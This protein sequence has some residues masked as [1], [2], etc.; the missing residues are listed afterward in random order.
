MPSFGAPRSNAG[1]SAKRQGGRRASN[2]TST[3]KKAGRDN[4]TE[5]GTLGMSYME[6]AGPEPQT[7]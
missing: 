7:E 2:A 5:L 6:E 3:R 1:I 4:A